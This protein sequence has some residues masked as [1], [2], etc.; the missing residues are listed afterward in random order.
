MSFAGT[1]GLAGVRIPR[2]YVGSG[3]PRA[4]GRSKRNSWSWAKDVA[5]PLFLSP[6]TVEYHLHKVFTKLG[7][8]SRAQLIRDGIP[9]YEMASTSA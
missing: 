8:A 4:V 9:G 6:R 7:I 2:A 1:T 5:A 3:D